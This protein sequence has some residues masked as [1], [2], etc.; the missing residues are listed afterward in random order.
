MGSSERPND[1]EFQEPSAPDPEQG[2]DPVASQ[3]K[4][5]AREI[6]ALPRVA[7]PDSMPAT[8]RA[9]LIAVEQRE[10]AERR[11][12]PKLRSLARIPAPARLWTRVKAAIQTSLASDGGVAAKQGLLLRLRPA[13]S[14]AA[15]LILLASIVAVVRWSDSSQGRPGGFTGTFGEAFVADDTTLGVD[16]ESGPAGLTISDDPTRPAWRPITVSR[17][18]VVE[19]GP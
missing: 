4:A 8:F 15:A 16:P 12:A 2:F 3:E 6:A 1:G 13:I 7:A 19:K 10:Q 18:M 11:L 17:G 14:I 9:T 5:L